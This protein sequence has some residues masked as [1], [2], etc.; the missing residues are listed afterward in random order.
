LQA[1]WASLRRWWWLTTPI[2]LC[3]FAALLGGATGG[4]AAGMSDVLDFQL[5]FS[6]ERAHVVVERWG[7]EGVAAYRGSM[8]LDYPYALA[9]GAALSGLVAR[10]WGGPRWPESAALRAL[11]FAPWLAALL[12]MVENGVHLWVLQPPVQLTPTA[13]VLASTAAALKWALAA[14]LLL[15]LL[16]AGLRFCNTRWR[17]HT[18]SR[19]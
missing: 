18:E 15:A 5:A 13:V 14:L 3:L 19:P 11:F 1:I 12:D 7:S 17:S 10:A 16:A 8:A 9:Y 6:V 4:P 2:A